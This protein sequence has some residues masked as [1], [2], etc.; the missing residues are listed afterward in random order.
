MGS[1]FRILSIAAF[2]AFWGF[3]RRTF[4]AKLSA[5]EEVQSYGFDFN[6][7]KSDRALLKLR[8]VVK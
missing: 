7:E 2:A 8:P 4:F 5:R 1:I 3:E 6:G